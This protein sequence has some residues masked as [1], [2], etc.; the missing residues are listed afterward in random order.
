MSENKEWVEIG[1]L[2]YFWQVAAPVFSRLEFTIKRGTVISMG[3]Y[4][5]MVKVKWLWFFDSIQEF[6][7]ASIFRTPEDAL[8]DINAKLSKGNWKSFSIYCGG[9]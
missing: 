9:R 3:K 5:V 7:I 6:Q 8:Q 1:S 2:V 4:S